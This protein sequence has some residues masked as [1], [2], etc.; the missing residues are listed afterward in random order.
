[1]ARCGNVR[2][3]GIMQAERGIVFIGGFLLAATA[4]VLAACGGS[5][6][7]AQTF[8]AG[9]ESMP[10]AEPTVATIPAPS[11]AAVGGYDAPG[12]LVVPQPLEPAAPGELIATED[13]VIPSLAGAPLKGHRVLYHSQSAEGS[14]IAVSGFVVYPDGTPPE[15]GWP[16]I[17]WAHGTTGI[18]DLC[19]PSGQIGL[20]NATA[21]RLVAEGFAVVATDYEGLGTPGR[22]PYLVGPSEAHSVLDSVRAVQ[23][24]ELPVTE[25]FIVFGYSQGGHAAIWASQLHPTYAPELR[26]IGTIAGAPSSQFEAVESATEA[27]VYGMM[28]VVGLAAAYDDIDLA[29]VLTADGLDL[30]AVVD[31]SCFATL[32]EVFDQVSLEDTFLQ[33]DFS[34]PSRLRDQLVAQDTDRFPTLRPL[35][36]LHGEADEVLPVWVS[37]AL[38]EQLCE[39]DD[40]GPTIRNTYVDQTHGSTIQGNAVWPDLLAWANARFAGEQAP[41]H[42]R[43]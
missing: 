20:A 32:A 40:Q 22:H 5:A 3:R 12:D 43:G 11:V 36:I 16:L 34:V 18:A 17:A 38:V 14:D 41:D 27:D 24:M 26:L 25:D 29:G 33:P 21:M 15:G 1:M 42:C 8:E 2:E 9:V 13:V 19:A 6:A 37:A 23:N 10:E 31:T 39:F 30:V 7:P 4:L 35:L 28:M